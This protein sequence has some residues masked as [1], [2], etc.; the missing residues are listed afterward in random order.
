M[1]RAWNRAEIRIEELGNPMDLF[2]GNHPDKTVRAAAEACEQRLKALWT[3]TY[4]DEKLYAR[5]SAAPTRTPHEAKLKKD[6]LD[7]AG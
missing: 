4:Q 1:W 5:I 7:D 6:L 3:E 2:A